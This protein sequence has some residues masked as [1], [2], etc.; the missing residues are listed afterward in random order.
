MTAAPSRGASDSRSQGGR[1]FLFVYMLASVLLVWQIVASA[2]AS[3]LESTAPE[4]AR[5]WRIHQPEALIAQAQEAFNEGDLKGARRYAIKALKITPSVGTAYRILGQVAEFSGNQTRADQLYARAWGL[6]HRDAPLASILMEKALKQ[7][8]Y[9]EA[10]QQAEI[11]MRRAPPMQEVIVNRIAGL[12]S[13]PKA[14]PTLARRLAQDPDW[15]PAFFRELGRRGSYAEARALY[16]YLDGTSAPPVD[17]EL[18]PVLNRMI[19]SGQADEARAA[20]IR[21]L[22]AKWRPGP[23]EIYNPA[24]RNPAGHQMFDWQLSNGPNGRAR[25]PE[26]GEG[27]GLYVQ[28]QGLQGDELASQL[29]VLAP[30]RYALSSRAHLADGEGLDLQWRLTC[31][32]TDL[33]GPLTLSIRRAGLATGQTNVALTQPCNATLH[34][35]ALDRDRGDPVSV[36][37]DD[38]RLR[39]A[40]LQP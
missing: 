18:S 10:F 35:S 8:R 27:A 11:V 40:E 19:W 13:D 33:G 6:T 38:V 12:A 2:M 16:D 34:L 14:V 32:Q 20:W 29:L 3:G 9:D 36:I 17:E 37:V 21:T 15:R 30:G 25:L 26:A 24:F 1:I 4:D 23:N 39:P 5:R 28:L 7:G 22:P 31:G